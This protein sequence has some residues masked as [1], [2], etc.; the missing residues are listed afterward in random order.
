MSTPGAEKRMALYEDL[1]LAVPEQLPAYLSKQ[2][3][4]GGKARRIHS[5]E[6][7]DLVPLQTG[8]LDAF[9][10]LAR[11]EYETGI[12][13]TYVLPMI[14]SRAAS[15]QQAAG[16]GELR[17]RSVGDV[18]GS[19][20][21]TDALQNEQFLSWLLDA[22][23][24]KLVSKGVRGELR[25]SHTAIFQD[26]R[27]NSGDGLHPRLLRGEQSNSSVAYGDRLILKLFRRVEEGVN[28]DLEI[29]LFLTEAAH[30]PNVPPVAGAFEYREENG[31]LVSIGTLQRFVANQGDAWRFTLDSLKD[32]REQTARYPEGPPALGEAAN[33]ILA[34]ESE[35]PPIA[36]E[37]LGAYLSQ[38]GL[39]GKRTAQLHLALASDFSKPAFAPEAFTGSFQRDFERSAIDLAERNFGLLREKREELQP[40]TREEAARILDRQG[41][42]IEKLRSI[43]AAENLGMRIRIHGD[44]HLGQVLYTGSDFMIIDFEGEPARPLS[45]RRTKR[46]ALQDVAGMVR[47]F[48]YAAF[49][50][51]PDATDEST[52][53]EIDLQKQMR[54]SQNWYAW[55][56]SRFLHSYFETA[57]SG[58]FLPPSR[59]DVSALL[60]IYLLEK[61]IY[62]LG[63]ELNNRPA[64]AGI[65]L[66]GISQLLVH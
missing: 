58:S 28:P 7:L 44:Y 15:G 34:Y 40:K 11:A 14:V 33:P 51:L 12:G 19:V 55:A 47:S 52:Q 16:G 4:F 17:I 62:E 36:A 48:H 20:V 22:V 64:W 61:A 35:L 49:S 37:L 18:N 60:Q 66:A 38:V 26:I 8:Q 1:R 23:E 41:E 56:A 2:R 59:Q 25:A 57:K 5:A 9:L 32:F 24:V 46:S 31:S 21:L 13:D 65:P 27:S 43:A 63:Y 10:L 45:E 42:I 29:E 50:R 3:W 53:G 54:W 6:I 39:L 30:F